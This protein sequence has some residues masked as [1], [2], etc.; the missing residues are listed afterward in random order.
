MTVKILIDS[1]QS[2]RL[3]PGKVAFIF[4]LFKVNRELENGYETLKSSLLYFFVGYFG[5]NQE[6]ITRSLQLPP[7]PVT[8]FSQTD[9]LCFWFEFISN[10]DPH[11]NVSDQLQSPAPA[12]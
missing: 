10:S 3:I 11:G 6:P 5:V 7:I 8:A 9:Q 2:R 1:W 4:R 12:D